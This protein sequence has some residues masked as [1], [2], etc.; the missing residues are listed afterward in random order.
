MTWEQERRLTAV[1]KQDE[2]YQQLLLECEARSADYSGE[3]SRF[4][5][6]AYFS[7]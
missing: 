2:L 5:C 4:H 6:T 7:L 1:V 3:Y